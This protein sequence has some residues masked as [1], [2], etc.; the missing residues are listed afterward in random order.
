M[1]TTPR[2]MSSLRDPEAPFFRT[3]LFKVAAR[4]NIACTYC[5]EYE[6]AD[7]SWRGKP[8]R[9]SE[10]VFDKAVDRVVEHVLTH[11]IPA[12]NFIFHGGEPL[13]AG[14]PFFRHAVSALRDRVEPHCSVTCGIQ[15]NGVLIDE[16]WLDL[17]KSLNLT[18]GVSVDGPRELHDKFRI[19]HQGRSTHA[20]VESALRLMQE[21]QYR[22]VNSGMLCV[23]QPQSDP[24]ALLDWFAGWG[25]NKLDLLFPHHNHASPPPYPHSADHGYG[26]GLWLS[27]A[28]D[29]WWQNDISTLRIRIFEDIIHL[30]LGGYFSVE[31]LGLSPA[32][33]VV[34]QTDGD[35]E[36]LDSLKST[37]DGAVHLGLNIFQQ[38]MDEVLEQKVFL[39]RISRADSLCETCKECRYGTV[40]GG[41]Y[42]PHR[43]HRDFGFA[44]PSVYCEDLMF[45]IAHIEG[46][47]RALGQDDLTA[48]LDAAT[49]ARSKGVARPVMPAPLAEPAG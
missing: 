4:C 44:M 40:C 38:R 24:V 8:A 45:L 35:Y 17:L 43:Y 46:R 47:L 28:F 21:E 14:K 18:I 1:P 34:I 22:G 6:L 23:I 41:G 2:T 7:Q 32:R 10:R 37:F 31:S 33:I 19:D 26:I 12:V 20:S 39:D 48:S 3:F 16:S 9:M 30:L 27:K 15:S 42:V 49:A 25:Q 13:L 36:A 11:K 29:H 5:Y